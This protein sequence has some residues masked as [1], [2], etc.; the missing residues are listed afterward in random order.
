[1]GPR[2]RFG[3]GPLKL[4]IGFAIVLL[5]AGASASSGLVGQ[6]V[7]ASARLQAAVIEL[8]PEFE[9]RPSCPVITIDPNGA[10][11]LPAIPASYWTKRATIFLCSEALCGRGFHPG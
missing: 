11:P 8:P 9:M 1:M 2:S 7:H 3:A 4:A 10:C 5:S 6:N